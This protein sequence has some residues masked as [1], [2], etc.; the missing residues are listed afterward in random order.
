MVLACSPRRH[1]FPEITVDIILMMCYKSE[2]H[3][4]KEE[5]RI[6]VPAADSTMQAL[7]A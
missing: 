1:L 6:T 3:E 2:H 5:G 4:Y 7:Q